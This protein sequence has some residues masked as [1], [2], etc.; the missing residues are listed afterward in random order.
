MK[1]VILLLLVAAVALLSGCAKRIPQSAK[2]VSKPAQNSTSGTAPVTSAS[3]T[4]SIDKSTVQY[5]IDRMAAAYKSMDTLKM[6]GKTQVTVLVEGQKQSSTSTITVRYK[7]PN[8]ILISS[9]TGKSSNM[10]VS[11]GKT[12][13]RYIGVANVYVAT[14]A[15]RKL[16]GSGTTGGSLTMELLE[17]VDT[18]QRLKGS[19]LA[20]S[21]KIGGVDCNIIEHS[22]SA[23]I[24]LDKT[25]V[26]RTTMERIWIGKNDYLIRQIESVQS[27]SASE[28]AKIGAARKPNGPMVV[29]QMT[30]VDSI[31]VDIPIKESVFRFTPP[32]GSKAMS[33][34]GGVP[35]PPGPGSSPSPTSS[36][37]SLPPAGATPPAPKEL[38]GQPAP[39]FS[40][41]ALD[42]K[43]VS[44]AGLKGKTVVV[45]FWATA[46]PMSKKVMPEYQK[47]W[48]NVKGRVQIVG[49]SLD[50]D[51]AVVQEYVK[52][53]GITFPV[54][55]D[56]TKTKQTA[57]DYSGGQLGLPTAFVVD[58]EGIVIGR[59]VGLK[60][61]EQVQTDLDKALG[62]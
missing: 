62:R 54:L 22:F 52:Q 27:V 32:K 40:M 49:I 51:K 26:T 29:T 11:N 24:M 18:N 58:K 10:M 4:P 8:K 48:T 37:G 17:G 15:P 7:R 12:F 1:R 45:L 2:S 41:E 9:G 30:R 5:A 60:S 31:Q 55:F 33:T 35:P 38:V 23:K 16:A 44:L 3:S 21:E 13:Y 53:S 20:G 34:Q 42:G 14:P 25:A 43:L 6:D 50:G 39:G 28:L 59:I 19:K 36:S 46:S 61:A 56:N 57:V 47:V